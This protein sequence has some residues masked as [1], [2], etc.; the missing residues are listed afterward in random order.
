GA[1]GHIEARLD[2]AA[3][4]ERNA[5]A[6]IGADQ[7]FPT[8]AVHQLAAAGQGAHGG[9]AAAQIRTGADH[10]AR[11]DAA[12]DH[13]GPFG[14]GVE[15]DETFVHDGG[16]FAQVCAEA[17]TRRVSDAQAAGHHVVAHLGKLV[18]AGH[19]QHFVI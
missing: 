8:H 10:H 18:H 13:A 3:I 19:F 2:D 6:R 15:V 9:T 16:A 11:G 5:D 4:A 14:A 1:G 17:H 7:A 12:F